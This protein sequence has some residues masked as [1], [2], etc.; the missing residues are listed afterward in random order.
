[1]SNVKILYSNIRKIKNL[2]FP[3]VEKRKTRKRVFGLDHW[4]RLKFKDSNNW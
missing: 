4:M 3:E 1:M 2:N